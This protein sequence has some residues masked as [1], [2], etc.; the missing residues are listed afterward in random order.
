MLTIIAVRDQTRRL[1]LSTRSEK[2]PPTREKMRIAT[3]LPALTQPRANAEPV[4]WY[5]SQP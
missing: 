1:L 3:L 5:T 2:A 4:I